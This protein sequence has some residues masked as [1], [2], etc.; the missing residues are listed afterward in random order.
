VGNGGVALLRRSRGGFGVG[1]ADGFVRL[2]FGGRRIGGNL[3]GKEAPRS[4]GK[5][6]PEG[7]AG[8][9]GECSPHVDGN[10][11]PSVSE[12]LVFTGLQEWLL[13]TVQSS[14]LV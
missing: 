3:Q 7:A 5:C 11:S 8:V 6:A 4:A 13:R 1:C 10:V 14:L 12:V 9:S 2:G